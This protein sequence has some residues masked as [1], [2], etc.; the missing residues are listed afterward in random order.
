MQDLATQHPERAGANRNRSHLLDPLLLIPY[1]HRASAITL[2]LSPAAPNF[3]WT[4][5]SLFLLL[6]SQRN[7]EGFCF[8]ASGPSFPHSFL[9]CDTGWCQLFSMGA[10]PTRLHSSCA[11]PTFTPAVWLMKSRLSTISFQVG[12]SG[13]EVLEFR[14]HCKRVHS[15]F[16]R[17]GQHRDP[18]GAQVA[19]KSGPI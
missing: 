7:S 2:R 14:K 9:R 4:H 10:P 13:Y 11:G 1:F 5:F 3:Q 17:F 6:G 15:C 16:N 18:V 8:S 19:E 12:S